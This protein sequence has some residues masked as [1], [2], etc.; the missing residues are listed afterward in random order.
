MSLSRRNIHKYNLKCYKKWG[1][2]TR[3]CPLSL[4][5]KLRNEK[6]RYENE[7]EAVPNT[8]VPSNNDTTESKREWAS[9]GRYGKSQLQNKTE[10]SAVTTAN[11]I[12]NTDNL[13]KR[14]ESD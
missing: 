7:I 13:D 14:G 9:A 10:A 1:G 6:S 11:V 4:L 3:T 5:E 12:S 2:R 8:S